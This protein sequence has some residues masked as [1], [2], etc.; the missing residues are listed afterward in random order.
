MANST[1]ST[2]QRIMKAVANES[3]RYTDPQATYPIAVDARDAQTRGA[4]QRGRS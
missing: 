3:R 1:S 2:N 4:V